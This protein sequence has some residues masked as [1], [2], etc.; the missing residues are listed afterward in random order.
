LVGCL[1][2]LF[3]GK[4][5]SDYINGRKKNYKLARRV[6]NGNDRASLI[7]GY[8][9]KFEKALKK[10]ESEKQITSPKKNQTDAKDLKKSSRR[11]SF[12]SRFIRFLEWVGLGAGTWTFTT[13]EKVSDFATDGKTIAFL[14]GG[15]V[16]YLAFHYMKWLSIREYKEGRYQPSQAPNQ[17]GQTKGSD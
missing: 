15:L 13:L 3:T 7:A 9:R 16:V 10:S 11:I 8:A 12:I 17:S 14:A 4:K 5:L 6:V 1:E 2:G